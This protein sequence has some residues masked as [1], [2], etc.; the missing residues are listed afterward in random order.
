MSSP[1]KRVLLTLV[2]SAVLVMPTGCWSSKEIE[3]VAL[4]TG[5]ALDKGQPAPIEKEFESKGATYS[6]RNKLMATLQL[7][8]FKSQK[9]QG[10]KQ[11]GKQPT[12]L[13]ISGSGDSVLEILRQF[14][15][16]LDRPLMGHHLKVIIISVDLLRKQSIEQLTDFLLRDNEIRPSTLVYVSQGPA[17]DTLMSKKLNEVPSF[18]ISKAVRNR[19]RTSKVLKPVTLSRLDSLT[20]SKKSFVLQT[21]VTG[22]DELELSGAS[23]INATGHWIGSLNQENTECLAWLSGDR[24][25]GVIKTDDWNGETITYEIKSL[26]SK[27]TPQVKGDQ[28]SFKVEIHTLGRLIETWDEQSHP[29]TNDYANALDKRLEDKLSAM[30]EE[31][32]VKLQSKYKSD[33]AGFGRRLAIENPAAWKKVKEDWDNVFSRSEITFA[34]KVR[35][36][37]FGSFTED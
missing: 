35:I 8:P 19:A 21:L 24:N 16:R 32:M 13:N 28:I 17:R 36:N 33:V 37:D 18:H 6:K 23:I 31:L 4:F 12:F 7:V 3:D 1:R 10:K 11:D 30:M 14:S 15:I 2:L 25:A 22:G 27:I 34:I 5:I 9:N 26:R 29:T 20:H